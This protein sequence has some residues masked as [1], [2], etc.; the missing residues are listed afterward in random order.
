MLS[1]NQI[2]IKILH[3]IYSSYIKND[4]QNI[5]FKNSFNDYRNLYEKILEILIYLKKRAE[6]EINHGLKKNIATENDLNPNKR[7]TK[8]IILQKIQN[9]IECNGDDDEKK[10]IAK[11]LF[12]SINS[13]KY[14][15]SYMNLKKTHIQEEKKVIQKILKEEL[16]NLPEIFDYLENKSI[17]WNDDFFA[18]Q[19]LLS[20]MIDDYKPN[21]KIKFNFKKIKIFKDKDDEFFANTLLSKTIKKREENTKIIHQLA[22]NWDSDRISVLDS[23][24]M[25]LAITEISEFK[26][27]PYKVSI[28]E[29]IE[30]S[31]I[32]STK[33]SYEF[34]NGILDAF[35]KKKILI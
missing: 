12:S 14:F 3:C 1:R 15:T 19:M 9:D 2:R 33:K 32:Y 25:Q 16:F 8:N 18:I 11:K 5:E 21:T 35:L 27:I 26:S 17:Y 29:Y 34:I 28:N 24:L 23:I 4:F 7:F 30:I 31:K 13:K 20:K 10:M 6:F 22:K